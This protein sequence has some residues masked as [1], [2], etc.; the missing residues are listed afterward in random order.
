MIVNGGK[1][2]KAREM[3]AWKVQNSNL[4]QHLAKVCVCC[5]I[6]GG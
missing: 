3:V 2:N 6:R 1:K 4:M 5:K